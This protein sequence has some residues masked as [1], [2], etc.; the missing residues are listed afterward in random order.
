MTKIYKP[1][2][3]VKRSGQYEKIGPRGGDTNKEI[4]AVSGKRFPPYE[5]QGFKLVDRT[6]HKR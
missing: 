2:Q 5:G 6:K 1:G 3:I 4:T